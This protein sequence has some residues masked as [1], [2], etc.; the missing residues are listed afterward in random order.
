MSGNY[1]LWKE[2][3]AGRKYVLHRIDSRPRWVLL[4]ELSL[5]RKPKLYPTLDDAQAAA[6][7]HAAHVGVWEGK[8]RR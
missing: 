1:Y 5:W 4:S 8:V 3:I 6:K 7:Q 2:L